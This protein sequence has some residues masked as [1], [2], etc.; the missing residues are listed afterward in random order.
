MN[1]RVL[2]NMLQRGLFLAFAGL[3]YAW[4]DFDLQLN[5]TIISAL[6]GFLIGISTRF[7]DWVFIQTGLRRQKFL[8]VFGIRTIT[9]VAVILTI[10]TLV[11]WLYGGLLDGMSVR[12]W[13]S[14]IKESGSG[15]RQNYYKFALYSFGGIMAFQFFLLLFRLIGPNKLVWYVLG[16]YHEPQIEER[17]F[18]F[19]DIRSSTTIAERLG[20][21]KWHEFLNDFFFDIAGPVRRYKGEIYQ[22][23]GDEVVISWPKEVGIRNLNAIKCFFGLY[24]K[25][26]SKGHEYLDKY[27]YEPVFKSGYH[28]GEVIV[29]E[30]GDYKREIVF[31]GDTVNTASRIQQECNTYN[32]RLLLS[33]DLLK[34]LNLGDEFTS[35]YLTEIRLRGKETDIAL[36]SLDPVESE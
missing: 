36:Y 6:S 8:V 22:Y 24:E 23:V 11:I 25:L 5:A 26:G 31:H 1:F 19:M 30:I 12:D 4:V 2:A 17:I 16:R 28:V 34:L 14:P 15:L 21:L 9:N 32:R 27:G 20:A 3:L 10:L 33:Y 7:L 18:M 13:L 35:E 29:G